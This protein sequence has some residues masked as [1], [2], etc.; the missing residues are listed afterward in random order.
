MIYCIEFEMVLLLPTLGELFRFVSDQFQF[1]GVEFG[2][3][4]ED[5]IGPGLVLFPLGR[6]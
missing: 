1:L 2:Q 4:L 5:G 6:R 3:G